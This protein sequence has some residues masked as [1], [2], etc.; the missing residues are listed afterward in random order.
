M[1]SNLLQKNPKR[2]I[3]DER[4]T[5]ALHDFATLIQTD[6]SLP[7]GCSG[8]A[9]LN[10]QG[11]FVGLITSLPGV[12]GEGGGAYAVPL[13]AAM[14]RI[15]RV[16]EKG[17]EVEYGFL[18][19]QFDGRRPDFPGVQQVLGGSP[20]EKAGLKFGDLIVAVDDTPVHETD[21]LVLAINCALAGSTVRFDV[22][23]GY[24]RQN[25]EII[26]LTLVKFNW[27]GPAI[28][29][30]KHPF[31]RGMRV[32]YTSVLAQ[33]GPGQEIPQGVYVREVQKGSP[34]DAANLQDAIITKI[35]DQVVSSPAEFYEKMPKTGSVGLTLIGESGQAPKVKLE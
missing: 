3:R 2:P 10:L 23:R 9:L 14:C 16:L 15:I 31:V 26:P 35:N 5:W 13:N 32:D 20:A 12:T 11:E 1:V 29:S 18:G 28:Y 8:G 33:R 24:N 21:D 7:I 34:A 19:V 27:T 6:R 17:E 4:N 22:R 30:V 25:Q